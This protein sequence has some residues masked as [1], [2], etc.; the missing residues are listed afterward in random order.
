MAPVTLKALPATSIVDPSSQSKRATIQVMPI[1]SIQP[2]P[3]EAETCWTQEV[4]QTLQI[5]HLTSPT[6]KRGEPLINAEN[7]LRQS[8]EWSQ[9]RGVS[10]GTFRKKSTPQF[11]FRECTAVHKDMICLHRNPP[12]VS[13]FL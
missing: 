8:S 9:G 5:I 3:G 6:K 7:A 13:A 4:Q 12:W 2:M 1:A 10:Q 11:R